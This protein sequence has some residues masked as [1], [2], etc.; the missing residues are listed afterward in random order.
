MSCMF[1]ASIF[2]LVV[3]ILQLSL[4]SEKYSS[5]ITITIMASLGRASLA[6]YF[7]V[8]SI[9]MSEVSPTVLRNLVLGMA[10]FLGRIGGILAP[11]IMLLEK[12]VWKPFPF[13]MCTILSFIAALLYL[14]LPET[15][16]KPLPEV[17]GDIDILWDH[18]RRQ[19]TVS[20]K[21][22]R[23]RLSSVKE[24][25]R[26]ANELLKKKTAPLASMEK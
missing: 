4:P 9:Y 21:S 13:L 12:H 22:F 23:R 10:N 2:S 20:C 25:M 24:E 19:S 6:A 18:D 7:A 3:M 14:L 17:P 8:A 5:T 11:Q 15:L 26:L 16:N 1:L